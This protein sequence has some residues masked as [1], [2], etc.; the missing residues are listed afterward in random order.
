QPTGS[1][2]PAIRPAVW[3]PTSLTAS[4][5]R[6]VPA[7]QAPN[8]ISYLERSN[9]PPHISR[10]D[11][12]SGTALTIAVGLTPLAQLRADQARYYPPALT[13]LRGSHPGAF[14]V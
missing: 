7:Y 14:E 3:T 5:D 11:F 9:M 8:P 10:R 4:L 13:G 1:A 2:L 6:R 12:L